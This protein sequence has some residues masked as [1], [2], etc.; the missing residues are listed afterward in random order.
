MSDWLG[1]NPI[2]DLTAAQ[3]SGASYNPTTTI[4]PLETGSELIISAS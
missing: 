2:D 4:L 1:T 3:L